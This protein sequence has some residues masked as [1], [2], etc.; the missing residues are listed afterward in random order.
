MLLNHIPLT[1]VDKSSPLCYPFFFKLKI[2]K[3]FFP[4]TKVDKSF[5]FLVNWHFGMCVLLS[6]KIIS[7]F[8]WS[9]AQR[10]CVRI[11]STNSVNPWQCEI[12][13]VHSFNHFKWHVHL[14]ISKLSQ[15]KERSL[16]HS[17]LCID[18]GWC[19]RVQLGNPISIQ[20]K[21]KWLCVHCSLTSVIYFGGN[22]M[23]LGCQSATA[24]RNENVM[25]G[26]CVFKWN[27]NE[28]HFQMHRSMIAK[29]SK[30]QRAPHGIQWDLKR[31]TS[32]LLFICVFHTN[33]FFLFFLFFVFRQSP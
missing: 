31:D 6:I 15:K 20:S 1:K 28:N 27:W 4:L 30:K 8:Q 9:C 19:E 16:N 29:E 2:N 13:C 10:L 33:A 23:P 7:V 25:F 26:G 21:Q 12:H 24:Q 11:L 14:Q 18:F 3:S 22:K 32:Y 5:P 17:F